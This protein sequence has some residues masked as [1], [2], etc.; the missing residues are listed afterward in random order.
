MSRDDLVLLAC[1]LVLALGAAV[2]IV[3]ASIGIERIANQIESITLE[4]N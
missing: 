1:F 4:G 2:P 3:A